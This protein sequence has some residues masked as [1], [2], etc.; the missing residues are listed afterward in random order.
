MLQLPRP[1]QPAENALLEQSRILQEARRDKTRADQVQASKLPAAVS[2]QQEIEAAQEVLRQARAKAEAALAIGKQLEELLEHAQVLRRY[3]RN[4]EEKA[5]IFSEKAKADNDQIFN[6]LCRRGMDH[7]HYAR[8]LFHRDA[9]ALCESAAERLRG[10]ILEA[11]TAVINFANLHNLTVSR[12]IA[13]EAKRLKLKVP[14]WVG[15]EAPAV[16]EATTQS[17]Q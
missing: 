4:V 7:P 14:R 15:F 3:I 5:K 13:D 12:E 2:A 16:A 17:S 9:V 11:D 10:E 1:V 8:V 6:L